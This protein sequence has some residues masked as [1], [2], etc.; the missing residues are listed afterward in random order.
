MRNLGSFLLLAAAGISPLFA[1]PVTSD[2]GEAEAAN[3]SDSD[4]ALHRMLFFPTA[5]IPKY[6]FLNVG[7]GYYSSR[8][9]SSS[10]RIDGIFRDS[11]GGTIS[12]GIYFLN[13]FL[14]EG[15]FL[16]GRGLEAPLRMN[17]FIN[18]I[19]KPSFDLGAG[20]MVFR[21]AIIPDPPACTRCS[22]G[23]AWKENGM[24]Y[25]AATFESEKTST[26]VGVG[27]SH[28]GIGGFIGHEVQFGEKIKAIAEIGGMD[29]D[30]NAASFVQMLFGL[31]WYVR[32]YLIEGSIVNPFWDDTR[33]LIRVGATI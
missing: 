15:D 29:G 7:F 5:R 19:D 17:F 9:N 28:A 1:Q 6:G 23:R 20:I 33:A 30:S 18:I 14:I 8:F 12:G 2:Q 32:S 10:K 11:A 4:P 24:V 21:E 22:S 26:T 25:A 13:T 27:G 3:F 31:R 16:V